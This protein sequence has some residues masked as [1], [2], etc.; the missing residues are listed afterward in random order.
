MDSNDLTKD[1]TEQLLARI[2]PMLRYLKRL[3][4]RMERRSFPKEDKLYRLVARIHDDVHHLSVSLHYL[5]CNG[6][7]RPPHW[8]SR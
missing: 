5:T 8:P 7:G 4:D 1:Q 3:R 2:W 6:V